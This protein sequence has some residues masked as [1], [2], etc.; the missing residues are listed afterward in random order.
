M[1]VPVGLSPPLT[2]H[3]HLIAAPTMAE[4]G[5]AIPIIEGEAIAIETGMAA[6][7]VDTAELSESPLYVHTQ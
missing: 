2:V 6:A 5:C 4:L 1:I 7:V 3:W